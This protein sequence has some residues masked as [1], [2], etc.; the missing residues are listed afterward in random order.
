MA[1]SRL[2][3]EY[4]RGQFHPPVVPTKK[5]TGQTIIVTGSNVGMG[6]EGARHFVRLDAAKVILAV[7][8]KEKGEAAVKDI[9][10]STKRE[11]IAEAWELDLASYASVEAF[12]QRA[13]ALPRLDVVVANAGIFMYDF[14]LAE[15]NESSITINVI[16]HMM[17]ALLLLPK[18]RETAVATGKPS[19]FT[20]T[21]SF[22]HW[23]AD[24]P[25]VEKKNDNILASLNNKETARMSERYYLSKLIQLL[26]SR[27]LAEELTKSPK[28]GKVIVS[29]L[30]PGFVATQI[31]RRSSKAFKIYLAVLRKVMALTPEE[32]G[33]MLV[34]ASEGDEEMHGKY[35]NSGKISEPSDWVMSAEGKQIQEK[36]WGEVTALLESIHPGIMQNL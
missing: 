8:S 27:E 24:K 30:N 13:L 33:R 6:L 17:L 26:V 36:L 16:S 4:F 25:F 14:E 9:T 22:T 12:A 23:W 1:N 31:M 3:R 28:P 10:Q 15:G 21:G 19:T 18:L 7:R 34:L 35:L 29:V 2:V 20:F 11:G 5:F 32:G